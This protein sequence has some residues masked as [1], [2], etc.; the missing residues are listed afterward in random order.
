MFILEKLR[1]LNKVMMSQE[2]GF[3]I[4]S[5]EPS[6]DTVYVQKP[7]GSIDHKG[8]EPRTEFVHMRL[9]L[10]VGLSE[11]GYMYVL[12]EEDPGADDELEDILQGLH[13]LQKLLCQPL[14]IIHIVL[15]NR[16]QLP[17]ETTHMVPS[18]MT[19]V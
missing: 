5:K 2:K 6:V 11:C 3:H 18:W 10:S 12:V 9:C 1:D 15:Q 13:G 7:S 19:I 14:S 8:W 4:C 16:G 17:V